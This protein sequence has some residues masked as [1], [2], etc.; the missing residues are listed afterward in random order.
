MS[1]HFVPCLIDPRRDCPDDCRLREVAEAKL[2][3][4]VTNAGG[5][6]MT[7]GMMHE[8]FASKTEN[9]VASYITGKINMYEMTN[10]LSKCSEFS[11]NGNQEV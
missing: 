5:Q 7:K 6:E 1:E 3:H 11:A 9:Q 10:Q 8:L 2:L 4:A